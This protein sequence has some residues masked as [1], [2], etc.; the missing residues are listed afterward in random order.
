MGLD[1]IWFL[2]SL[3]GVW[4]SRDGKSGTENHFMLGMSSFSRPYRQ[5][6]STFLSPM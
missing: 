5:N 2:V 1:L 4:E 6:G 3:V